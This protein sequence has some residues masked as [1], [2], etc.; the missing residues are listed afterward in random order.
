MTSKVPQPG[1][2]HPDVW[3]RDLN[4]DPSAG[5]NVGYWQQAPD[6]ETRNAFDVKA[7]HRGLGD[8][9]DDELKQIPVL[10]TG[11]RLEQGGTYIDL[12]QADHG[13]FTATG[14]MTAGPD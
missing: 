11:S 3:R 13:P 9:A 4:P 8:F 14:N 5:Q 2:Q 12:A 6:E 10:L 1:R 7:L